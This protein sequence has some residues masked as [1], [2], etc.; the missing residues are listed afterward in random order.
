MKGDED[1][2][3]SSACSWESA[4]SE[5]QLSEEDCGEAV[6]LFCTET[7]DSTAECWSFME[8]VHE[9]SLDKIQKQ[10]GDDWTMYHKIRLINHLRK[11]G[12]EK[13]RS[14]NLSCDEPF[15]TSEEALI[16]V[17][18]DDLLLFDGDHSSDGTTH[19]EGVIAE[20]AAKHEAMPASLIEDL[21]DD[22]GIE[23]KGDRGIQG[24]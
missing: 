18:A 4:P 20:D 21:M 11:L 14:A 5:D 15:W 19:V 12:P 24:L 10:F 9:F 13:A 7:F 8:G 3:S 23:T 22:D 2:S 16:P 6:S 17:L 1:S